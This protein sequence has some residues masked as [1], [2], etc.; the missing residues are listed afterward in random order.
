LTRHELALYIFLVLAL[1]KDGIS[2]YG[3][4]T[5]SSILEFKE[6]DSKPLN[7]AVIKSYGS[8]RLRKGIIEMSGKY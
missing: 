5:V 7:A 1:D 2:F 8:E 6:A 4:K 3:D